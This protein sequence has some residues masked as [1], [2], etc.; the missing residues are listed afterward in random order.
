MYQLAKSAGLTAEGI[1]TATVTARLLWPHQGIRNPPPV[2][3]HD[4]LTHNLAASAVHQS[5]YDVEELLTECSVE[6]S[7]ETVRRWVGLLRVGG[8]LCSHVRS[9]G[10]S[11]CVTVPG[12][13][14]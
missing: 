4:H 2:S 11:V 8:H 6:V 13:A 14:Q 7:N 9:Q 12:Y 3:T 1:V 5:Y 10:F